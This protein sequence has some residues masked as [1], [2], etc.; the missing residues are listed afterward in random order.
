MDSQF[1]ELNGI[2][3]KQKLISLSVMPSYG[4][5]TSNYDM[6]WERYSRH[7][8]TM[9]YLTALPVMK[10]YKQLKVMHNAMLC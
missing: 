2:K 10:L 4:L 3:T 5:C 8:F 7:V 6:N 1:L 9:D